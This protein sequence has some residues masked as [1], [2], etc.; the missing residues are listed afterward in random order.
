VLHN[1]TRTS[2]HWLTL[3]LVGHKSNR[4]AIGAGVTLIGEHGTQFATVTTAGSYLSSS[5]KRL[6][7][8]LGQDPTAKSIEIQWASGIHQTIQNVR[9]DQILHIDEPSAPSA[10]EERH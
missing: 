4:D 1:D 9:G 3:S 7:F 5:D 8:G 2:N 6:H 10:K